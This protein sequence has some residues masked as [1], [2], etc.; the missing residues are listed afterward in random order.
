MFLFF[1]VVIIFVIF[2]AVIIAAAARVF[3][4]VVAVVTAIASIITIIPPVTIVV[5][6]SRGD[7][8]GDDIAASGEV[9]LSTETHG[10]N[11]YE[12]EDTHHRSPFEVVETFDNVALERIFRNFWE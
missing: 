9:R 6:V 12:Q 4:S 2:L 5:I 11:E 7:L 8:K 3:T 1:F 10:K